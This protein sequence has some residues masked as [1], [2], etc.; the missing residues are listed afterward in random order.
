MLDRRRRGGLGHRT[1]PFDSAG[2]TV[3]GPRRAVRSVWQDAEAVERAGH[4][5][6]S[7]LRHA[8]I[9]PAARAHRGEAVACGV[10]GALHVRR[11]VLLLAAALCLGVAYVLAHGALIE[12]GRE[13]IV[14]R[15]QD[16]DGGWFESRLWIVDDG[17]AAWL[18]GGASRWMRNL[19][20]RPIV[21][22][23][24]AGETRRYRA[25]VVRGAHPRLH[26]LLREKYGVADRWVRFVGPDG[27]STRAV[28]LESLEAQ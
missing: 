22:V 3:V 13:V 7:A 25:H 11:L 26:E 18:H 19:E 6:L 27:E 5:W 1:S 17:G 20:A 16:E 28:R 24:R 23:E 12:V 8:A 14:L 2:E 10:G 21:E 15:T 4:I 9:S